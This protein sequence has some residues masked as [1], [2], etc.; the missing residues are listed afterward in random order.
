MSSCVA[1]TRVDRARR[2][3]LHPAQ[4]PQPRGG[5]VKVYV[6]PSGRRILPFNDP[7]DD[8]LIQNRPLSDWRA[9]AFTEA[10]LT[11]IDAPDAPCLTIPDN[12]LVNG[13][14]L[15]AFVQGAAGRNAV[16]V[17]GQSHFG[18]MAAR[19]QPGLE[20]IPGGWRYPGVRWDSG[21]PGDPVDVRV[22]PLEHVLDFPMPSHYS[23]NTRLTL[24]LPRRLVLLL[25]HWVHI[26]WANQTAGAVE[27]QSLPR[28]KVAAR[29]LW[30]ALRALS[31][32]KW[33]VAA[34]LNRIG[35]GCDIHPTAV[36]EASNLGDNV[37]IGPFAR[38]AFSKIGDGAIIMP[39][40]NVDLC[41]VGERS[42]IAEH[43]VIRSC[44]LY[45]GSAASQLLMQQCVLGR[46]TITTKGGVSLDLNFEADIKVALDG[47]M[48]TT[49]LRCLGSAYGHRAKVGTG[50][51]LS[52]GRVVP[53][54]YF[55][56]R[57]PKQVLT[58]LPEG[59]QG[60]PLVASG[61]RLRPLRLLG[62]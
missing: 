31:I 4:W 27:M 53:N 33:R 44:V 18:E 32:N 30:A 58:V 39:G 8:V 40:A 6:A 43:C 21:Q 14:A 2:A 46:D 60:Q 7:A 34:K 57:D 54:D 5:S 41:V 1:G 62:R 25:N 24:G 9:Q 37:I 55:L 35:R 50:F 17:L 28:W 3:G 42:F 45:P 29:V 13:A 15:T 48:H 23:G 20:Q 12:L 47:R 59:L 61:R 49:G 51:Y 52:P 38:V 22:D 10:G 16:L 56:I 36:V 11:Q 19:V 26:L